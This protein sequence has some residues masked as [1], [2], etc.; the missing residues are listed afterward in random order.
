VF[1][2]GQS[3]NQVFKLPKWAAVKAPFEAPARKEGHVNCETAL[4]GITSAGVENNSTLSGRFFLTR[5]A[6]CVRSGKTRKKQR[7]SEQKTAQTAAGDLL[8]L[9]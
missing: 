4:F 2:F 5:A 8:G 1:A 6:G 7:R 9:D 3:R